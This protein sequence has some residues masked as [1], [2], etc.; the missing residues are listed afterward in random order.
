MGRLIRMAIIHPDRAHA[1]TE[2]KKGAGRRVT[3]EVKAQ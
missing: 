1:R 2:A 3:Q